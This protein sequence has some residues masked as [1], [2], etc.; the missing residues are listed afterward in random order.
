M[1]SSLAYAL[2]M[3]EAPKQKEILDNYLKNKTWACNSALLIQGSI[4]QRIV[5]R[6]NIVAKITR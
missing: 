3:K 1:K 6:Q 2:A 5:G 4:Y